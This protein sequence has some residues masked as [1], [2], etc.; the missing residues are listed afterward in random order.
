MKHI[1][2]F[3][4]WFNKVQSQLSWIRA[5]SYILTTTYNSQTPVVYCLNRI[6]RHYQENC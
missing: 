1:S 2:T 4:K 6:Y 5:N 3:I